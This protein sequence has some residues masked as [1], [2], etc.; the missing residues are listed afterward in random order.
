VLWVVLSWP[1]LRAHTV[2]ARLAAALALSVV[3]AVLVYAWPRASRTLARAVAA[4]SDLVF[5]GACAV[6]AGA[7]TAWVFREPM[8]NQVVSGDACMYVAQARALSHGSFSFPVEAPRLAQAAKFLFEGADGRM[9]GVFVPGY[10]LFLA[11]FVRWDLFLP[12][13]IVTSTLLTVSHFV[14]ARELLVERVPTRLA[15]LLLLPSYARAI[16]TA[17]LI[18]HAFTGSMCALAFTA[19]LRLRTK[20]SLRAALALGFFGGWTVC[21]RVLDGAVLGLTIAALLAPAVLQRRIATRLAVVA[22]FC[23][24]PFVG[25]IAAQQHFGTGSWRMPTTVTYAQRSDWPSNCLHLGFGREV[26]CR[27]EHPGERES[28]GSDGYTPDDALRVVRERTGLHGA[29]IFGA[30]VVSLAGFVAVARGATAPWLA[31]ALFPILLTLAYGLFYYGN[32]IVHG[33]RHV[34]P[35]APFTTTLVALAL[36]R[37]WRTRSDDDTPRAHGAALVAA[38]AF[39]AVMHPPRWREGRNT[40]ASY[41]YMRIDVRKLLREH[42][43]ERGLVIFP[44]VHSYLVALDPWRDGR[45]LVLTHD[46]MAGEHDLRRAHPGAPVWLVLRDRRVLPVRSPTPAPGLNLEFERAWPSFQRPDGLG[47]AILHT[48][49]CCGIATSGNRALLLFESSPGAT[50]DVPFDV[51]VGGT[52]SF[53]LDGLVTPDAGRYEISIDDVPLLTWDGYSPTRGFKRGTPTTA[54]PLSAGRHVFRARCTGRAPQSAGFS[55]VFDTLVA[56]TVP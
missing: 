15:L 35:A 6:A 31:A 34:F 43:I 41:Q 24:L 30:A 23:A 36:T 56:E 13:S 14:L 38:V 8:F 47:A 17:D 39:A 26:G 44:D 22:V 45:N 19:A 16:E 55:A 25:I 18:S 52:F 50:L 46:D 1:E 32:A 40:T 4:P 20:P 42:H 53:R 49:D 2:H 33:A 7:A 37:A 10:P 9:H 21:A 5:V 29:E 27:I 11:P 3:L 54:R 51:A 12:A 28:F 48:L